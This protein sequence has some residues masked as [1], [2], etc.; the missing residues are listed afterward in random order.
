MGVSEYGVWVYQSMRYGC[1]RVWGMGVSEYEVW[2]YQ[3]MRYSLQDKRGT[4]HTDSGTD[5]RSHSAPGPRL[6]QGQ[7]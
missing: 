7:W 4:G 5:A 6:L 2:V 1:I 3:S